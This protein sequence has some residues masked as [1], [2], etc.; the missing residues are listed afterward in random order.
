MISFT[1]KPEK[2]VNAIAYFVR[3]CSNVGR[4]KACKLL[5]FADKEH[6]LRYGRPITG[7]RYYRLKHGPIPTKGLN[8]LRGVSTP[9]NAALLTYWLSLEDE[10]IKLKRRP[11]L[12]VF[13]KSDLR[14][15]EEV[16]GKYGR[17]SA[18]YLSRLSHR[19]APWKKTKQNEAIDFELFFDGRPEADDIKKL[20]KCEQQSRKVLASYRA[21]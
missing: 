7:D 14:V 20:V 10:S 16:C 13:S 15:L 4:T 17:Y 9:A 5:Y 18:S 1:F 8:M 19:E 21:V 6:L 3:N 12:K 11:D 2:L